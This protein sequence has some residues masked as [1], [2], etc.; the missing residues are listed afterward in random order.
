MSWIQ[1]FN[2]QNFNQCLKCYKSLR[3]SKLSKIVNIVKNCQNYQKLSK[4]SKYF[5]NVLFQPMAC[6]MFQNQSVC[7]SV[8][9][10]V[11]DKV[12]YWAVR[13]SS[14]QLKTKPLQ[15]IGQNIFPLRLLRILNANDAILNFYKTTTLGYTIHKRNTNICEEWPELPLLKCFKVFPLHDKMQI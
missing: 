9:Q 6:H 10:S 3:L 5:S 1:F 2:C 14:G 11:S 7:Q 4:L 12:T 8:S 13:L 15:N